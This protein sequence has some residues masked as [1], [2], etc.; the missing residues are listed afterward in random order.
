M[1]STGDVLQLTSNFGYT[2][3]MFDRYTD[4]MTQKREAES[5]LSGPRPERTTSGTRTPW[6][7]RVE[8]LLLKKLHALAEIENGINA[9]EKGDKAAHISANAQLHY[10]LEAA[11]NKYE[12]RFGAIPD[13]EDDAGIARHVKA[14]TK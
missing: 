8:P 11:V 13:P 6:T 5:E 1:K 2:F 9:Y 3:R 10:I 4:L 14:R 12:S 7:F